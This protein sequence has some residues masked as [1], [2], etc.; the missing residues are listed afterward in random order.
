[1]DLKELGGRIIDELYS[2]LTGGS[3]ELPLPQNMIINWVQPGIL[4]HESAF[5]FAIAGP[6]A[7]PTPLTLDYFRELAVAIQGGAN[8]DEPMDRQAAIDEAKRIYQQHLLGSWEQWSRLVDFIPLPAPQQA[9]TQWKA[10]PGQ[11]AHKHVSVVYGQAGQQL[12]RIYQDTL[13]RCEVAD[14]PLTA[15]Q[16]Q[17]VERMKALL[18]EEVEVEDFLTG[19]MRTEF[20]ES[21]LMTAYKEKQ[22]LYENA[23][24]DY[25]VRLARANSGTSADLI[26]WTRSGGI[27]K[28]RANRALQDWVATGYKM[29]VE[30]AQA[31]INQILG[32]SMVTWVAKLK[33]DLDD[34]E[35]NMQGSF[36]YPFF[37]ATVLPGGFARNE[38]WSRYQERALHQKIRSSST[39]RNWGAAGGLNLGF[40]NIGGSAGGSSRESE[41]SFKQENFGIE[42]DYTQ[43]EIVR[44]AFNPNFFL[45]R[46]WR[47]NDAF[48]RD[49]G[50]LH[51]DGRNPPRGAMIGY[52]T[53][54]LFIRD[55]TIHSQ[56]IANYMRTKQDDISAG[57]Y[58]GWGPF[59]LGGK[60]SQS[61]RESENNLDFHG[62]SITVKGL[63][64]VAFI[65]ALFPYTANPS[66]DVRNWI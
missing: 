66:P 53:K 15:H 26:E 36:G 57:G 12:S 7:G 41:F 46:G 4:F 40:I 8:G 16:E 63:Q 47:P 27:Y 38:G 9:D 59:C 30:R 50:P 61:N 54:A 3:A 22:I 43:V 39:T 45:S 55:L 17:L 35:N 34:I 11:G 65:S 56:D 25:A 19:E 6:Y 28:Q 24:T 14:E 21:R 1:M 49:N 20:R 42:F 44:P 13:E 32:G 33:A 48:I 51:S 37:P 62:A 5:D 18:Q 52:P 2:G 58:F 64:L 10:Q 29:D 31:T 23:V 60:Y